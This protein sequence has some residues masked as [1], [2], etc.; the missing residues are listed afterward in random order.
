MGDQEEI[1]TMLEVFEARYYAATLTKFPQFNEDKGY[2]MIKK[3][4][5]VH[6][7]VSDD[8]DSFKDGWNARGNVPER[9]VKGW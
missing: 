5:K 4:N 1:H 3:G 2:F 9:T 8:W 7:A 6:E